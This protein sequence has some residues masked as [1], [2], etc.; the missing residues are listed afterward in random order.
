[1]SLID[2]L[3][4]QS[5]LPVKKGFAA[6]LNAGARAQARAADTAPMAIVTWVVEYL[7]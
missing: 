1:M 7:K 6:E 5:Q 4:D 2:K 3:Y